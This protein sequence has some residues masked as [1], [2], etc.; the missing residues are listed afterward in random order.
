MTAAAPPLLTAGTLLS[1]TAAVNSATQ[2][3]GQNG[4]TLNASVSAVLTQG[5]IHAWDV[6]KTA[7][8]ASPDIWKGDAGKVGYTVTKHDGQLGAVSLSGQVRA[9]R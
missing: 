2:N 3:N 9:T 1:T 4:T 7:E 5:K 8:P 6:T